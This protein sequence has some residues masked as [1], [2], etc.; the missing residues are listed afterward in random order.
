MYSEQLINPNI[1]QLQ[2]IKATY[3][4]QSNQ[5]KKIYN[6]NKYATTTYSKKLDLIQRVT[7]GVLA[8][9]A[10]VTLITPLFYKSTFQRLWSETLT[11]V[12]YKIV[13]SI[14]DDTPP[15][16][17]ALPRS[18]VLPNILLNKRDSELLSTKLNILD[19]EKNPI[20]RPPAGPGKISHKNANAIWDRLPRENTQLL[21]ER[22]MIKFHEESTC[23]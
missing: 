5:C 16:G 9:L 20:T 12:S 13:M 11:G 10:T 3:Q 1:E 4:Q 21:E 19:D 8:I 14:V 17:A 18:S 15:G 23:Y 6:G 7:R 22:K 2:L